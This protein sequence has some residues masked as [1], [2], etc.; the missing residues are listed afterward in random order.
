MHSDCDYIQ[1]VQTKCLLTP[2]GKTLFL[3]SFFLDFGYLSRQVIVTS[4][5][6]L[7]ISESHRL[8]RGGARAEVFLTGPGLATTETFPLG[9]RL[10]DVHWGTLPWE[11]AS[12]VGSWIGC[13]WG[14]TG[15][16]WSWVDPSV[17]GT[18]IKTLRQ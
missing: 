10:R 5:D 15:L 2:G 4:I 17:V 1:E 7:T 16:K 11:Y 3:F 12:G 9:S 18:D 14:G 6:N 8:L 13:R